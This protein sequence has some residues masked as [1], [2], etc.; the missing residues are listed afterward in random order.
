[1]TRSPIILS[2]LVLASLSA[3]GCSYRSCPTGVRYDPGY[4]VVQ[5]AP[6]PV[7]AAVSVTARPAK[8]Q[9]DATWIHGHYAWRGS[10]VW[11]DGYWTQPRPGYVWQAPVVVRRGTS[12]HYHPGYW[13]PRASRPATVYRQ[14]NAYRV[15]VSTAPVPQ[16]VTV[17]QSARP[18]RSTVQVQSPSPGRVHVQ[19][20]GS[21]TGTV[22]VQPRTRPAATQTQTR[23]AA[24]Q[25]QTRPAATQTQMRT[26]TTQ[27]QTRPAATQTQMRTAT[28]Q[29][30]TRPAA[31]Q[32]PAQ[33]RPSQGG[34][35]SSG[36]G[37]STSMTNQGSPPGRCRLRQTRAAAG[38]I[39]TLTGTMGSGAVVRVGRQRATVVGRSGNQLRI[40]VPSGSRGGPVTVRSGTTTQN[41]GTLQVIGR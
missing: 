16:R 11:V 6:P 34:Q 31:S 40:Q 15:R 24:T 23:P 1:M 25:T 41:C 4:V 39:V 21:A 3:T 29:T 13:R 17:Q 19:T 33:S 30:Q 5:T 7:R 22:T 27:T 35:A 2:A 12:Y 9:T 10:W 14:P 18:P 8:P 37:A 38:S 20:Q 32:A 26:A 28:T 36:G